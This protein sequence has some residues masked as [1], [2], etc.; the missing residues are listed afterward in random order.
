M[1]KDYL[2]EAIRTDMDFLKLFALF[3]IGLVTGDVSLILKISLNE[4]QNN[5]EIFL[6]IIGLILFFAFF[7]ISAIVVLSILKNLKFLKNQ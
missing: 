3:I 1:D 6:L 7:V 4:Q 2:K 5:I